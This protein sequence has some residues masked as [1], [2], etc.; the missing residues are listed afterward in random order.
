MNEGA[1]ENILSRRSIRQYDSAREVPAELTELIIE[2]ACAAPS[3]RNLRPWRFIVVSGRERLNVM[4]DTMTYGKM[5]GTA[6]L[7]IIVCG[8]TSGECDYSYWEEDC[9][10][11]MQNILLAANAAGLGS[12][13]VGVRQSPGDLE[14]KL[15][16]MFRVPSDVAILGVAAIG[17][18][19]ASKDPHKGIE[20][21][22][23]HVNKW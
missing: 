3:A 12:V 13:W 9:S 6:T 2:C 18:P 21:H 14:S 20:P 17:Y 23:V 5:L 11:A 22:V 19:I 7:A 4:A 15:K 8:I 10:A 1:I 16:E